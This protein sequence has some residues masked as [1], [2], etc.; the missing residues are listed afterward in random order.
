MARVTHFEIS[1]KNV[2]SAIEF[3]RNVFDWHIEKWDGPV[4]YWLIGTGEDTETGIDGALMEKSEGFPPVVNTVEVENLD[5][6]IQKVLMNGG[7][8]EGD[9]NN[10]PGVGVFV[11]CSDR[12]GNMFGM[13]QSNQK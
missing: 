9:I 12:E 3:Y 5:E 1:V 7:K 6:S 8:Q 2:Q 10:I 11:Y 4:D 13:M